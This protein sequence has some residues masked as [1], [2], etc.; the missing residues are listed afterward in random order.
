MAISRGLFAILATKH[1]PIKSATRAATHPIERQF[2]GIPSSPRQSMLSGSQHEE[3]NTSGDE[4]NPTIISPN[5]STKQEAASTE[6]RRVRAKL[7]NNRI[8]QQLLARTNEAT[9]ASLPPTCFTARSCS[10]LNVPP[11][12]PLLL[13]LPLLGTEA[14]R[15]RTPG[16]D[17]VPS[18]PLPPPSPSPLLLLLFALPFVAENGA[19]RC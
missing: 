3:P 4:S 19:E 14:G 8:S 13:L 6:N 17:P 10:S 15:R 2:R 11:P 9:S 18:P 5:R 7:P 16:D 12:P 1:K